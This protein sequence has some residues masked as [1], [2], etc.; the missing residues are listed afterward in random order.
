M[1]NQVKVSGRD[2]RGSPSGDVTGVVKH[3][4]EAVGVVGVDGEAGVETKGATMDATGETGETGETVSVGV[5][6]AD[7]DGDPQPQGGDTRGGESL[8]YVDSRGRYVYRTGRPDSLAEACNA[9]ECDTLLER[10]S[11]EATASAVFSR[12]TTETLFRQG[13]RYYLGREIQVGVP[14]RKR[15][16]VID[17]CSTVR[18]RNWLEEHLRCVAAADL[19]ERIDEL[20]RRDG[21]GKRTAGRSGGKR[22]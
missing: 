1:A 7:G 21:V 11:P 15:F 5:V 18:A 10:H 14:A 2:G 22:K 13:G 9:D 19:Y 16:S 20:D 3:A 8:G 12:I 4:V 6:K 17:E